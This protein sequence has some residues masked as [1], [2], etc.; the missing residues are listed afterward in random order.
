LRLIDIA[1]ENDED[2]KQN[3]EDKLADIA[4]DVPLVEYPVFVEQS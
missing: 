3:G 2:H 1:N 4:S